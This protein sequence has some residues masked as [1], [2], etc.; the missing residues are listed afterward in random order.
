MNFRKF[1][2]TMI[3]KKIIR[4]VTVVGVG[5]GEVD[6]SFNLFFIVC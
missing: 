4:G 3:V 1:I 5:E 2:V 6:L